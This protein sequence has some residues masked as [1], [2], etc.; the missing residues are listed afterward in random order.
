LRGE[1][2]P[3]TLDIKE[4]DQCQIVFPV[5]HPYHGLMLRVDTVQKPNYH[6][7]DPRGLLLLTLTRAS[8]HGN[9]Y[10]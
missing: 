2:Y 9:P 3:G 7:A 1:F 8:K 5:N 6:P 10:Q 4:Y